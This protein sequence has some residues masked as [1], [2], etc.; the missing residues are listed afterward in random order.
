MGE[1]YTRE[2]LREYVQD[3]LIETPEQKNMQ[4]LL[5]AGFFLGLASLV[6]PVGQ[7]VII[8]SCIIL[9]FSSGRMGDR[10]ARCYAV[11]LG[12]IVPVSFWLVRN[13][14]LLGTIFFHT[15][16]GGH[17]LYLS[18]AR[19]AMY[20]H[21]C[22]YQEARDILQQEVNTRITEKEVRVGHGLNEIERC[23]EHEKLAVHYFLQRPYL[24]MRFWLTDIMRASLSLYSAELLYLESGRKNIDYFKKDRTIWSMFERYIFPETSS[25]W[26][27]LLIIIEIFLYLFILLGFFAGFILMLSTHAN[28]DV[29]CKVLPFMLLF[30][31]ISLAGGYA[32]MRLP[33]EPF[34]IILALNFWV[35]YFKTCFIKKKSKHVV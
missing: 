23:H 3:Y 24:T 19:V 17:F 35:T 10:L 29:W 21:D 31:V 33:I 12:W 28:T 9:L 16:P 15:L 4:R 34:L 22:S 25:W 30:I 27:K 20:V 5:L 14:L 11:F 18:A 8:L 1:Q 7:Y 6:R 32:R 2:E 26:L 13:Y